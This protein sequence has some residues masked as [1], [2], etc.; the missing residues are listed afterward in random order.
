MV[1][2]LP[3]TSLALAN[4]WFCVIVRTP[5]SSIIAASITGVVVGASLAGKIS[6]LALPNTDEV[7]SEMV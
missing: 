1:K 6:R 5:L 4:N 3:S 2:M 7:P